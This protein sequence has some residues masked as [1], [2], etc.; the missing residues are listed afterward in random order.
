MSQ[1]IILHERD[2]D[3]GE[4]GEVLV[5]V[6]YARAL[7]PEELFRAH[8]AQSRVCVGATEWFNVRESLHDIAN[9]LDA[10]RI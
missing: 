3:D 6:V 1:A 5:V 7:T 8:G 10:R 2:S 9:L 4:W